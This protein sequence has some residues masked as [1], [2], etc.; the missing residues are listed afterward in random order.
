MKGVLT[1][2]TETGTEGGFWAFQDERFIKQNHPFGYCKKC[3]IYLQYAE[4]HP[5]KLSEKQRWCDHEEYVGERWDYEG[6]HIL[7]TGDSLKIYSKDKSEKV[8]WDG[9][10]NLQEY[11]PF[12]ED[13][14]GFWIHSDQV[15]EKREKWAEPFFKEYPAELEVKNDG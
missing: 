5:D 12:E 14:F 8:I 11:P 10:I 6:L 7:H 2:H 3:G 15:G 9:E 13:V 1:F 4:D